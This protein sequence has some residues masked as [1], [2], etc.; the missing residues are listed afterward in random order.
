MDRNAPVG[1]SRSGEES[2]PSG[3]GVVNVFCPASRM[4]L[5]DV[6]FFW[7]TMFFVGR[8]VFMDHVDQQRK[9]VPPPFTLRPDG[10]VL[11]DAKVPL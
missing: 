9:K 11:H 1:S 5:A 6:R 4:A 3:E 2:Q 8:E 7:R 10:I